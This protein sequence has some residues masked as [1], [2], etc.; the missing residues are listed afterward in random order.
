MNRS[1]N[2]PITKL[3]GLCDTRFRLHFLL[4]ML[5]SRLESK[6][7][8]KSRG[9][10]NCIMNSEANYMESGLLSAEGENNI[11]NGRV[12]ISSWDDRRTYQ[13]HVTSSKKDYSWQELQEI[14]FRRRSILRRAELPFWKILSFWDGTCLQTLS[15]DSLLWATL[16]IYV[17]IR[18]QARHD[19][20]LPAFVARL[21]S[22]KIDVIGGFLS[23][24]LVIFVNQSSA[25]LS[26][27]YKESMECQQRICEVASLAAT[28]VPVENKAAARRLVRYLNASHV[29]GY[30]GL[31]YSRTYTKENVF[32]QLQGSLQLLTPAEME[33]VNALGMN[34]GGNCYREIVSW[35]LQTIVDLE[36]ASPALSARVASQ[37]SD[38]VLQFQKAMA[39]IYGL[40]DQPVLF[41]YIHF[42][43][44]LTV[45]YLPI[46]AIS[47][48]YSAGVGENVHWTTDLL[49]GLI[50]LLQA[51]FVIGL[52][53]LGQKQIDPYG[54]DYE[55][56]SVLYYIRGT[57]KRSQRLLACPSFRPVVASDLDEEALLTGRMEPIGLPWEEVPR[58]RR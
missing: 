19:G 33:R 48:A 37:I 17:V 56:L 25:R 15:R 42:L 45:C 10:D 7:H 49:S 41:F 1:T 22:A 23:F 46:F 11:N 5:R 36:H 50:V 3:L 47:I 24:F 40:N 18:F 29:A 44:L 8:S 16:L 27:M 2:H 31:S 30:V 52:R 54:S 43:C 21:S 32:D 51:V 57:W 39:T 28:G 53:I 58:Q 6:S 34:E 35:C 26:D 55:D 20:N 4:D 14:E 9:L 38:R 13:Y 12:N